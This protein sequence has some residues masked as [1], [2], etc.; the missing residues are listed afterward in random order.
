MSKTE[1]L[2]TSQSMMNESK[3][4]DSSAESV[5]EDQDNRD[6]NLARQDLFVVF[7]NEREL[8]NID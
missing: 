7:T 1:H 4:K 6:S 8:R 3:D 2:N 5:D